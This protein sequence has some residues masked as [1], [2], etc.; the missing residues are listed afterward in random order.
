VWQAAGKPE[1]HCQ[2]SP[3]SSPMAGRSALQAQ[4]AA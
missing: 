4:Q 1:D 3:P 2:G